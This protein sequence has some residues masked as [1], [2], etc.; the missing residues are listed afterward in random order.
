MDLLQKQKKPQSGTFYILAEREGWTRHI[1]VARTSC[2]LKSVQIGNPADL[3]NP[4]LGFEPELG[5]RNKKAP[6]RGF[7]VSGGERG[8]RTLDTLL[9]YTPL[10][11][12]RLQPL[13]HL[14][15]SS[16]FI[17]KPHPCNIPV[18]R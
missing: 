7:C 15:N 18:E 2:G 5:V 6:S 10:A 1:H 13:G 14:S 3:S 16:I 11:G 8:I 9:T 4:L 17:I 12:E